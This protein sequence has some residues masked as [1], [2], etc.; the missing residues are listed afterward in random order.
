MLINYDTFHVS[1][2][3]SDLVNR[4]F[5]TPPYISKNISKIHPSYPMYDD[6][7]IGANVA[8]FHGRKNR[9]SRQVEVNSINRSEYMKKVAN[10]EKANRVEHEGWRIVVLKMQQYLFNP[11]FLAEC[12]I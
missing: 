4:N 1:T 9:I 10:H 7:G 6:K 3:R 5:K 8:Q 12:P 11:F 2:R